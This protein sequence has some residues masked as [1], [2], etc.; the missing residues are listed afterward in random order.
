[1]FTQEPDKNLKYKSIL[2][3]LFIKEIQ[4]VIYNKKIYFIHVNM[5]NLILEKSCYDDI[6]RSC[7]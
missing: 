3:I 7:Y 6:C 5:V 4:N 2:K 1:M